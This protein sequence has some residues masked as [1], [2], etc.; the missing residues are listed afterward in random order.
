MSDLLRIIS[1]PRR[2]DILQL[3]WNDEL[4]AG[5]IADAMPDVTF[6]AV[7]QHLAVLRRAGIVDVRRDG[8]HRWYR[9]NRQVLGPLA[10]YLSKMWSIKLRRLQTLA[11][12]AEKR[13]GTKR[14]Q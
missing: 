7:S 8:R 6:G 12:D 14:R 3:V 2:Q 13:H 11:E 4:S 10:E 5:M 9:A 1:E